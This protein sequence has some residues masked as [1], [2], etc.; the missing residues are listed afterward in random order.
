MKGVFI[1][2]DLFRRLVS[3]TRLPHLLV[4]RGG[5]LGDM[6]SHL[7]LCDCAAL[8]PGGVALVLA[9]LL[10]LLVARSTSKISKEMSGETSCCKKTCCKSFSGKDAW[11]RRAFLRLYTVRL[12]YIQYVVLA[13]TPYCIGLLNVLLYR[14]QFIYC[15]VYCG[16]G[17]RR[18]RGSGR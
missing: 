2:G 14:V 13:T 17:G 18:G 6:L 3:A 16:Y 11:R 5:L 4:V 15:A 7:L 1:I 12:Q 10:S 9:T 8:V